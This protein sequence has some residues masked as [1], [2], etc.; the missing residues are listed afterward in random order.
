MGTKPQA[1]ADDRDQIRQPSRNARK[2]AGELRVFR[3]GWL[4][5]VTIVARACGFVLIACFCL[6]LLP[7][8]VLALTANCAFAAAAGLGLIA[9]WSLSFS[10]FGRGRLGGRRDVHDQFESAHDRRGLRPGR[11][12]D[13]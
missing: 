5:L 13:L 7:C 2:S 12:A 1:L 3:D 8:L 6:W 11:L 9:L 10:I 4:I